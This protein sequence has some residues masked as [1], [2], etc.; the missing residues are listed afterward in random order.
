MKTIEVEVSTRNEFGKGPSRRLRMKGLIPAVVYGASK[1]HFSVQTETKLINKIVS[2]HNENA[3]ITLKS[4]DKAVNGKHV[5]IKVWDRDI[6]TRL[7][8]HVDFYE[9][10]LKKSVRVKVPLQFTGKAKGIADGGIVSPIVREVEV[11][12]LPTDI[13]EF[14]EVDVTDLGVGDSIHIEELSVPETVKKHFADNYTVVT[15]TY[16]K[17][18]VIAAPVAEGE[19]AAAVA[20]PEVIAKG[21]KDEEGNP[22]AKPAA[23]GAAPAKGSDKK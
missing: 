12:C 19:A 6:L 17:E 8:E 20:E 2:G 22:I 5:L 1:K 16:I 18:E 10:D 15:C 3:I 9:I 14:I 13:P 23:G 4:E 11:D 21:K 7:P